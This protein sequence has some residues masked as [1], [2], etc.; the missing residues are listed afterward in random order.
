LGLN[1]TDGTLGTWDGYALDYG[2]AVEALLRQEER[3]RDE[4]GYFHARLE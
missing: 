3:A 4:S 1:I 2:W